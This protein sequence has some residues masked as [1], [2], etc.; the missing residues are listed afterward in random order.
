VHFLG[1]RL[2]VDAILPAFDIITL[3]STREGLPLALLEGMASGAAAVAT[4]VGEIG[5]RI[6]LDCGAVAPPSDPAALGLAYISIATNPTK[7][8][9]CKD[10]SR[11]RIAD[12]YSSRMMVDAYAALYRDVCRSG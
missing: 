6:G 10:A 3:S 2:D 1:Q 8:Q 7:L 4:N 12:K 5:T 9:A 11:A